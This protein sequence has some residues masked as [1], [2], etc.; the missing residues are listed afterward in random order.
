MSSQS[1]GADRQGLQLLE[2]DLYPPLTAREAA[3]EAERCYFC[4][5]A[6]CTTACPTG[7]DIPLFIR[8]IS[9]GNASGAARTIFRDNILGGMCARDCP[10]ETLCEQDCVRHA[11]DDQPVRIGALQRYAT[12]VLMDAGIQPQQR[13]AETGHRVAVVGAGPAGLACA[14]RLAS[15]GHSVAL[16]DAGEKPGGLNE[17]GIATYKTANDFAQ[18]EV[19]YVLGIGGIDLQSGVRL[20]RDISLTQLLE[21]FEAVFLGIGLGDVNRLESINGTDL[22]GV[23]DAVSF[24]SDL[25]QASNYASVDA[26]DHVVVIGGGMTAIDAAVQSRLLGATTVTLAYRG[27]FDQMKASPKERKLAQTQ[28]VSIRTGLQPVEVVAASDGSLAGVRFKDAAG[29]DDITLSADRVLLAIGQTLESD[30]DQTLFTTDTGTLDLRQGRIA[31]DAE[32]RSSHAAVW[33]GGDCIGNGTDL[34]VA[35]VQ[36]GKLAAESMHAA[37]VG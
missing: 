28:G 31:V 23:A 8:Q 24:I 22:D 26:G 25:R 19:E 37:L 4:F 7:I 21:K 36:D 27:E 30:S 1:R 14:H 15:Y 20:G 12:D 11:P 34:T 17:Y 32:R 9:A 10:T 5:D 13:A 2:A 35:A 16:Y 3:V 33:A 18:R 29:G 6:P